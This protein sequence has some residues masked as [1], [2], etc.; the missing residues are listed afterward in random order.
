M[1]GATHIYV[2]ELAARLATLDPARP[3]T[4]M[5]ASGARAAIAASLLLR[6]GFR[7]VDVY[8]GSMGAWQASRGRD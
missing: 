4:T 6:A 2:G 1:P 3:T 8:L 7:T 5:C